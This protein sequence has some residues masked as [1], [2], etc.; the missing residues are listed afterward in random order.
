MPFHLRT[1][2]V[3]VTCPHVGRSAALALIRA[4]YDSCDACLAIVV[5]AAMPDEPT[6]A[7]VERRRKRTR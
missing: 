6:D 1:A 5:R 4:A 7:M 3:C 2:Q